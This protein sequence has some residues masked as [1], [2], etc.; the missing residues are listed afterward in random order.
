[1]MVHS[2]QTEA[3][4]GMEIGNRIGVSLKRISQ[5]YDYS[6]PTVVITEVVV[7][8]DLLA[9]K[10]PTKPIGRSYTSKEV[11]RLRSNGFHVSRLIHGY[12]RVVPSP[13]PKKIIQ[14]DL[15]KY[16]LRGKRIV[17]AC[18][19]GGIPL[20]DKNSKLRYVDAVIDKDRAS[21]LLAKEIGAGRLIILTN[22]DGAYINFGKKNQERLGKTKVAQMEK[23][24]DLGFFEE[25]SMKPKVESCIDFVKATGKRAEIGDMS[26]PL[27]VISNRHTVIVP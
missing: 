1:M 9:F 4:I 13:N 15:I 18:G 26:D 2:A 7:G 17:I 11:E 19:G 23:Y 21:G 22:V 20:V 12:R 6:I 25:G 14:T 10:N 8:N 16:L 3:W 5:S 27:G 24:L